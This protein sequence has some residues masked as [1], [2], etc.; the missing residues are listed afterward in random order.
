MTSAHNFIFNSLAVYRFLCSLQ[1]QGVRTG[2][3]WS[4]TPFDTLPFLP[5]V[6]CG[7]AVLARAR[8]RV[9]QEEIAILAEQRDAGRY[10]A[11]QRWRDER[12]IPRR[13]LL[14]DE[15]VELLIDFDNMLSIDAFL[16]IVKSRDEVAVSE[17]WPDFD[18]LPARG[19]EG[20]FVHELVVPFE[21][22][23]TPTRRHGAPAVC[24]TGTPA[25]PLPDVERILPPTSRW[26]YLKLYTGVATADLVLRDAVVPL[27]AQAMESGAADRWFFIRFNDPDWHLRVRFGGQPQ[28]L[29]EV[30][31][32]I[33]EQIDPALHDGRI[34]KWQ[35]DTYEREV[36][37]YGGPAGIE[38]AEQIFHADSDAV[39]AMLTELEGDAGAQARWRLAVAGI[40]RMLD[41]FGF[42]L[43]AKRDALA[44]MRAGFAA[45]F[46]AGAELN[47]QLGKRLRDVS[48]ELY[49]LLHAA[50]HPALERRSERIAPVIA[51]LRA[52]ESRGELSMPVASI[53]PS[54]IHMFV[55]RLIRSDHRAHELVLYDLL[56]RLTLSRLRR[57]EAAPAERRSR[58]SGP[59]QARAE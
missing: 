36:E 28:R 48:D 59:T 9:T 6:R 40:D 23:R 58:A 18:E 14:T 44:A 7:R 38:L 54:F 16:P 22:R 32:M 45:E 41:D 47:R 19:P 20:R 17:V 35:L 13:V 24:G 46:E 21:R 33:G 4:W 49:E 43:T 37:R 15:D 39:L 8:W 34:W 5:R 27:V 31:G 10:L 1:A 26:I 2:L 56:H 50:P 42:E 29:R 25:C 57:R 52:R 51:E 3:Q 53:V 30:I 55:N 12:D 11:V